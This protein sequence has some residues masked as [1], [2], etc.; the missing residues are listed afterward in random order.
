MKA[1]SESERVNHLMDIGNMARKKAGDGS[2][3]AM[4]AAAV[5]NQY[6][7]QDEDASGR[8]KPRTAY[9]VSSLKHPD[10]VACLRSIYS[11]GFF[12]I[13]VYSDEERRR[14]YLVNVKQMSEKEAADLIARDMDEHLPYGQS[15]SETFHLSDFFVRIG[16][17]SDRTQSD[18]WRVLD[19]MFGNPKITPTF[20]EFAM[21]MAFSSSLR[22]A[23][24]SRQVGAVITRNHEIIGTGANDCPRYG[25]GQ[26]WPYYDE[27]KKH[28]VDFPE[29][30]DHTRGFDSNKAEK[31]KI[32]EDI[33]SHLG[34]LS[35]D[36]EV[37]RKVLNSSGISDIT[38]YG[39]VVHAEMDALLS[40]ARNGMD[41]LGATLYC[42]TFPCHNCAKHIV[43]AGIKRV[44]YVEPYPKSKAA[45]LHG[46]SIHLGF[47]KR[48][49]VV[50]FE[51]FIGVGPRRF[52]DLFSMSLGSGY[53]LSRKD[54]KGLAIPW[55]PDPKVKLRTQLLPFSYL[56][57]EDWAANRFSEFLEEITNE[58]QQG[59]EGEVKE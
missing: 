30:R 37:T 18:L 43:S 6:R 58:R 38:E 13:G 49:G 53:P 33:V 48:K 16:S 55:T 8:F 9:I 14:G 51:P 54:D 46:D 31:D 2:I 20:D 22:S 11:H 26:Y 25:G 40:C 23:D 45:D 39:R 12:L 7:P 27:Q 32:I 28:M 1:K 29:G 59:T 44:V 5:I 57:V 15:T 56:D 35:V 21:F 3:T 42:T 36:K 52:F 50:K 41:S 17:D 10:E 24:L 47:T 19:L 4:G 34:E